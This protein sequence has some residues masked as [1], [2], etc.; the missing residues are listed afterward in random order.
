MTNSIYDKLIQALKQAKNHNSN[1]ML[2]PEVILWPDPEKQWTTV[3]DILQ[4]KLP[5]LLLY[6]E[7]EP[8]KKQGPSIWLKCMVAKML[9]EANWAQDEIP[10]I[11]LPAVAKSD[12]RNVE[13]AGLDIQ[14]LIEYQ[15]TGVLFMQEN[16]RE[17]S[18]LA[19]LENAEK[20]LGLKVSK[21]NATKDSLKK[22]L[23]GVFQD[24]EVLYNKRMID[25][26]YLNQLMF[27]DIVPAI[28]NWMCKGDKMM[29]RM[30]EV[31]KDAFISL[32]KIQYDFVPDPKNIKTIAEKLGTQ[33][34]AWKTVWNFYAAASQ[35]YPEIENLLRM[36]KPADLGTGLFAVPEESWPQINEEKEEALASSLIKIAQKDKAKAIILLQELENEHKLRRNWV[37]FEMGR[38]ALVKS[39][40]YLVEM[41]EKAMENYSFNTVE[42]IQQYYLTGGYKVDQLMR[43]AFSAVKTERDKTIVKSIINLFYKPWLEQLNNRFQALMPQRADIFVQRSDTKHNENFIL[44]VDAFRYE[45]AEEFCKRLEKQKYKV[46]LKPG[47]SAIPT[48]TP[49]AKASVSPIANKVSEQSVF[50]DFRPRLENG[51]D[52]STQNFRESLAQLNYTYLTN[53]EQISASGNY[54]QEIGD[55][56]TKGHEEQANMLRRIEEL[57]DQVQEAIDNAFAK[58]IKR[59]KIVTDHGWLMLP[60]ALPKTELNA[61]LTETRWGRCALIKE[62]AITSFLHLPWRWNPSIY[63]AYAPGISFFKANVE[64]AHGGVSVQECLVPEVIIENPNKQSVKAEIKAV[65]WV[66]LRC[67]IDT[68]DLPDGYIV[69]IRAKYNDSKTTIVNSKNK[70]LKDCKISLTVDDTTEYKAVTIV[71]MDENERILDKKLTTVGDN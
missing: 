22:I 68:N 2:R 52:L 70:L 5:Q 34:N 44:F 39:L 10:I 26:D 11:Y 45:L 67:Y 59:I 63:I 8:T 31:K 16:G 46:V 49:T 48:L 27:P 47:W 24:S 35:R 41:A 50:N 64:Y 12:L 66:N 43:K 62:G 9:P 1:L 23:P 33:K 51:K 56:D 18:I 69:D 7:Y 58:G 55:I 65:R 21:D 6:G 36:V 15:Y 28:L 4:Q 3:I 17:W 57:F 14:P 37:W 30:D 13:E 38:S 53:S 20:G 54:W 29:N 19:F 60:G 71:L 40:E 42:A 32:C 61:G 25:A